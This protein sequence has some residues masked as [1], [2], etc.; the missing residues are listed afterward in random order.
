MNAFEPISAREFPARLRG[1]GGRPGT[2]KNTRKS[3]PSRKPRSRP[4]CRRRHPSAPR[5]DAT[6]LHASMAAASAVAA[7][8]VPRAM[9][10]GAFPRRFSSSTTTLSH[11]ARVPPRSPPPIAFAPTRVASRERAP[12]PLSPPGLARP[13]DGVRLV[14]ARGA[15]PTGPSDGNRRAPHRRSLTFKD[16]INIIIFRRPSQVRASPPPARLAAASWRPR[17]PPSTPPPT[18]PSPAR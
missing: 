16:A 10:A 14:D 1:R 12:R 11:P 7:V 8:A 5:N 3:P 6:L 2:V 18:A 17:P 15:R 4:A 13:S 9:R